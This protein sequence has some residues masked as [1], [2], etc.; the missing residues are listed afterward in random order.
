M[1]QIHHSPEKWS[2]LRNHIIN[3]WPLFAHC[4]YHWVLRAEL[5][6]HLTQIRWALAELGTFQFNA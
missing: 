3:S 4:S 5:K 1:K 6:A 2:Y